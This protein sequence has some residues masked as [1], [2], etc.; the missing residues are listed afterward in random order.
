MLLIPE[1]II[2]FSDGEPLGW[3]VVEKLKSVLPED[4]RCVVISDPL[5]I[6]LD[7]LMQGQTVD[8]DVRYVVN[9]MAAL[10]EAEG[11]EEPNVLFDLR[12]SFGAFAARKRHAEAEFEAKITDLKKAI[13]LDA[14]GEVD[15]TIAELASQSGLS[16]NLL[17]RLRKRIADGTGKLPTTVGEWLTWTID[18]LKADDDARD[19][20]LGGVSRSLMA[21]CGRKRDAELTA[22]ELALVL[23]G[24]VAW[25]SGK[26][27]CEVERAL[28]G[29]PD[30]DDDAEK[31]CPRARELVGTVV[32]RGLSF[33]IGLVSHVV[34]EVDPFGHQEELDR[35]VIEC[36]G[37]A[38]RK[39]YDTPA[40]VFLSSNTPAAL[41][42]VQLHALALRQMT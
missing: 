40:K 24:L 27:L 29:D 11:A 37:P 13:A 30:S 2:S 6:V 15:N 18:W 42:R 36:L 32:P 4:D 23:P 8:P 41:S 39:G 7:R 31:M 34:G 21:S 12:K 35:Q 38:V 1:P 26:P 9:R 33:I 5:E 3:K 22:E 28:G 19:S 17:L 25:I 10:R 14:Q 20:L 16:M